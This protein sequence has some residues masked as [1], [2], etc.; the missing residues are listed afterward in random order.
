MGIIST[1]SGGGYVME[2]GTELSEA[3]DAISYLS[4]MLWLDRRTRALFT[5]FNLYNPGTNLFSA[6]QLVSTCINLTHYS[7]YT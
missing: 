2:L 4:S 7:F 5:E 1:Y 6:V 3:Q